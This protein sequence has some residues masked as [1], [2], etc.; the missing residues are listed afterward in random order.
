MKLKEKLKTLGF[1]ETYGHGQFIKRDLSVYV[2]IRYNK[3]VDIQICK[4]WG[5][6]DFGK[7]HEYMSK[8]NYLLIQLESIIIDYNKGE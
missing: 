7:Y 1:E 6:K 3:I 4:V 8:L 5:L 2:Y